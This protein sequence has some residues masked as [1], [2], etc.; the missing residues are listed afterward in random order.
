MISLLYQ[1]TTNEWKFEN[2]NTREVWSMLNQ[3]ERALFDFGFDNFNWDSYIEEF[4]FGVRKYVL[5]E[6]LDN[7]PEALSKNRKYV[8]I[9]YRS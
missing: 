6:N 3:K 2:R 8:L 1:F 7:I 9:I 4:Y 5:H